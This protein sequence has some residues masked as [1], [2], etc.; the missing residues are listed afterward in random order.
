[1][2]CRNY[3]KT[4]LDFIS[5]L[6]DGIL[7]KARSMRQTKKL[8]CFSRRRNSN[9]HRVMKWTSGINWQNLLVLGYVDGLIGFPEGYL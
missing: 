8:L 9:E 7:E 5:Q 3:C 2:G 6:D 1:V 4:I